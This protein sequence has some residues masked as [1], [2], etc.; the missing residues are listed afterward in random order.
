V[1]KRRHSERSGE[2]PCAKDKCPHVN[3]LLRNAQDDRFVADQ[4]FAVLP[5]GNLD[6]MTG[7]VIVIG[8]IEASVGL[9]NLMEL[10]MVAKVTHTIDELRTLPIDDGLRVV[11]VFCDSLPEEAAALIGPEQRTESD[12]RLTA[13]EADPDDLPTWGQVLER[14]R[15]RT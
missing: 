7:V 15:L 1:P 11:K 6:G 12:R 13:H 2:S 5:P 4:Y 9:R 14:L 8:L 3:E 10:S